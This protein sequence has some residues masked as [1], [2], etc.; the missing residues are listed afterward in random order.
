[1]TQAHLEASSSHLQRSRGIRAHISIIDQVVLQPD[2]P[3]N[4]EE[5]LADSSNAEDLIR[6]W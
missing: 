5:M 4:L 2:F 1:M 6:N 3:E